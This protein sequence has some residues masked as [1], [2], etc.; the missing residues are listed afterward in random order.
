MKNT[1]KHHLVFPI[2]PMV[3]VLTIFWMGFAGPAL[4]AS[5]ADCVEEQEDFIEASIDSTANTH[6]Y[7]PDWEG[8]IAERLLASTQAYRHELGEKIRQY[9]VGNENGSISWLIEGINS[10]SRASDAQLTIEHNTNSMREAQKVFDSFKARP[11]RPGLSADDRFL[12]V[13]YKEDIEQ[14]RMKNCFLEVRKR[15]LSGGDSSAKSVVTPSNDCPAENAAAA[16]KA[17]SDIDTQLG[18]YSESPLG[19]DIHTI[20]PTTQVIMWATEA[21][22]QII[23]KYCPNGAGFKERV[24]QLDAAFNGAQKACRQIQSN[25]EICVPADPQGLMAS[26]EQTQREAANT[27]PTET[28]SAKVAAPAP[29]S[30]CPSDMPITEFMGCLKRRCR[31]QGFS[32]VESKGGCLICGNSGGDLGAGFQWRKCHESSEGVGAAR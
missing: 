10:I 30:L 22:A 16:N 11:W 20:T 2:F 25:P 26:Y 29:S 6:K 32:P 28:S 1:P 31:E 9:L 8:P 15:D 5:K 4:A 12:P 7:R 17:M 21:Q 13:K 14:M 19:K 24:S 23:R 27:R 3:G 18:V